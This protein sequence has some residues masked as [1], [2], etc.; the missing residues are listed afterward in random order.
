[1]LDFKMLEKYKMYLNTV[2]QYFDKYFNDQKEYICCKPGCS[3]CCKK[4]AYPCSRL[5]F[6]YL[7]LGFFQLSMKE[8]QEIITKI[9]A[10]KEEYKDVENKN[11]ILYECPFLNKKGACSVYDFRPLICR[12]FGLL[13]ADS[14]DKLNVPFC[15][16]LGLNYSKVYNPERKVI[17]KDLVDKYNYKVTPKAYPI[18]LKNLLDKN[19][20]QDNDFEFGEIKSL[21]EWL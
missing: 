4:G 2:Q 15:R 10:L 8:Q 9:Q 5:E 21:I 17:D 16:T 19:F 20:L 14:S 6:D 18:N 12:T 7:M 3:H 13:I 1:M 11:K